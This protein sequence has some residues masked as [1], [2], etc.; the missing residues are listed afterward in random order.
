[1]FNEKTLYLILLLVVTVSIFASLK[2]FFVKEGVMEGFRSA[3]TYSADF[4]P[5]IGANKCRCKMV[6]WEMYQCI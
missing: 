1:M 5:N 4:I 3:P 2:N 6:R